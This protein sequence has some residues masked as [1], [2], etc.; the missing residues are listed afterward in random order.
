M[1]AIRRWPRWLRED[2]AL[3]RTAWEEAR[4]LT[5]DEA[6]PV[7]TACECLGGAPGAPLDEAQ[8]LSAPARL[9]WCFDQLPAT[10]GARSVLLIEGVDCSVAKF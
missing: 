6:C 7:D 1:F 5:G 2:D 10:P 8:V 4:V 9:Q 3:P